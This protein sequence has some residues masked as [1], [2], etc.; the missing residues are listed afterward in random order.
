MYITFDKIIYLPINNEYLSLI[1]NKKNEFYI[2]IKLKEIV[3]IFIER[4]MQNI[5]KIQKILLKY[6]KQNNYIY[7]G[8]N[9]NKANKIFC[10]NKIM[11]KKEMNE[12]NLEKNE[13]IKAALCNFFSFSFSL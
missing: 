11:N 7:N 13:K 6:N 10:I 12:L 8:Y 9:N 4:Y 1:K 5:I 2:N 3:S